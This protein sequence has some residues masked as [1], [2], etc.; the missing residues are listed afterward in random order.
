MLFP[1]NEV[2]VRRRVLADES[3]ELL[4]VLGSSENEKARSFSKGAIP[5]AKAPLSSSGDA[6]IRT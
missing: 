5:A 2:A 3:V 1:T 6:A 4:L